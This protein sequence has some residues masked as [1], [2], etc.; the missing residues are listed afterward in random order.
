MVASG[1]HIMI[2][3]DAE[4]PAFSDRR[5]DIGIDSMT[6]KVVERVMEFALQ[7]VAS[8]FRIAVDTIS[9]DTIFQCHVLW[10][11]GPHRLMADAAVPRFVGID[12]VIIIG[13]GKAVLIEIGVSGNG[14]A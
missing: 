5:G 3:A 8:E 7:G 11:R 14:Q 13:H 9:D 6:A 1:I 10:A 2:G 12:L 4:A